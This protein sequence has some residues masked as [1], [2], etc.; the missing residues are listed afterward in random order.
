MSFGMSQ[1]VFSGV[2]E[3]LILA[4]M[5][6]SLFAL[7]YFP[8]IDM[9]YKVGIIILAFAVIFLSTLATQMLRAQKEARQAAAKA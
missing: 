9:T 5:L 8:Q 1:K 4:L 2:Q 6:V 3:A 7:M